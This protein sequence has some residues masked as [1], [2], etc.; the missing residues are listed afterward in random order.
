VDAEL[1]HGPSG[2]FEISVNGK[3][4]SERGRLGFPSEKQIIDAVRQEMG[5]A[6]SA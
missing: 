2:S 1:K 6:A 3:V 4:V 5:G